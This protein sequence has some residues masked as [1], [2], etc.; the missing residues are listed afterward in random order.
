MEADLTV[1][2]HGMTP[3]E[4]RKGM[5]VTTVDG[6]GDTGFGS[7]SSVRDL[8][9]IWPEHI[10]GRRAFARVVEAWQLTI[11]DPE[12]ER[13]DV[14]W[15]ALGEVVR[16]YRLDAI[17]TLAT[18]NGLPRFR[19]RDQFVSQLREAVTAAELCGSCVRS[20]R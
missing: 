3:G 18:V 2:R 6:K 19:S 16:R 17:E 13:D 14:L 10:V 7:H 15:E 5:T 4:Q 1:I 12:W 9:T 8:R 20:I 11:I